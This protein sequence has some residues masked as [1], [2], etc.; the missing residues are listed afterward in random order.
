MKNGD[1][2][3]LKTK[4]S[5]KLGFVLLVNGSRKNATECLYKLWEMYILNIFNNISGETFKLLAFN[6]FLFSIAREH[7]YMPA[8]FLVFISWLIKKNPLILGWI[9]KRNWQMKSGFTISGDKKK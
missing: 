3:D 4:T 1:G 2:E 5:L 7:D 6:Y 8:N 9:E